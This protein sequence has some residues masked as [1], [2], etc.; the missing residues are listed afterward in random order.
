MTRKTRI[1]SALAGIFLLSVV[2]AL[3]QGGM[4][5]GGQSG[6][7]NG[8]QNAT[9]NNNGNTRYQ[10]MLQQ[11][12]QLQSRVEATDAKL[13]SELQ[14]LDAAK[15]DDQKIRILQ[16]IL[17]NLIDERNYVHSQVLPLMMNGGGMYGNGMM[18]GGGMYGNGMMNRGGMYGNG[19]MN[20]GG[21]YGNGMMGN[22][23][24]YGNGMMNGGGMYGN[25]SNG[26]Q[27][28]MRQR[29]NFGSHVQNSDQQLADEL[30]K[31]QEAKTDDQKVQI[32]QTLITELVNERTYVDSQLLPMM[33]NR[34]EMMNGGMMYGMMNGMMPYGYGMN[35]GSTGTPNTNT[36]HSGDTPNN[37]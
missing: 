23:G 36:P 11:R 18:N 27:Q 22:G 35:S 29:R 30:Q 1:F 20:G 21:M 34:R 31:L 14:Q 24:M 26:Y 6:M 28:M 25:G 15:T 32:M 17:T 12:R 4:M 19:M 2:F 3:A 8:N 10:Q 37:R 7:M 33:M 16:T 9:P 5:G 13:T